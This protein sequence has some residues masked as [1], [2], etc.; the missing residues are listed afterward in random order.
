MALELQPSR[1]MTLVAL[2]A[3][4]LGVNASLV[5]REIHR[6]F[7]V[8]TAE[9]VSLLVELR[10]GDLRIAYAREGEVSISAVP[11]DASNID[12]ESLATRVA[13]T[14]AG[15]RVEIRERRGS[16]NQSLKLTYTIDVPYRTEIRSSVQHGNQTMTG[17]MGPVSAK[18][19]SG[20]IEV[21]YISLGV[22]AS[23]QTGNVS[24]EVV[25]GRIEVRTGAGNIECRRALQGIDAETGSGDIALAVVGSSV[26]VVRGGVGRI[27]IAGARGAL[28]ASTSAGDVHVKAI[29]HDSWKLRSRSGAVRVTLPPALGFELDAV[30]ASGEIMTS[31]EDLANSNAGL[32]HLTAHA[33]AGGKRVE[34][35]TDI[36]NIVIE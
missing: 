34:V 13:I 20:D 26:A 3:S 23:A 36:G 31:R 21:T 30:T 4:S 35:R 22:V 7:A 15:N 33:N 25:G 28:F 17:V 14:Q 18:G 11:Q 27:D 6:T 9:P 24:C 16:D 12:L 8:S 5:S 29:P 32:R 10:E 2:L 19:G 1:A